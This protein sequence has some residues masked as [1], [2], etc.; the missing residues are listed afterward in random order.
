MQEFFIKNKVFII[1]V[2]ATLAVFIGGIYLSSRGSSESTTKVSMDIL[3]PA[4]AQKISTPSATITL[5][6]FGDYECPACAT[7]N[8]FVKKLLVDEVDKVNF[9]F[10]DYPLPQHKNAN[11]SS[12]AA[13]AAALQGKFW[14]MHDKLFETQNDWAQVSDPKSIFIGYAKELGLNEVQFEKDLS[15]D[16][17]KKIVEQGTT[18][19]SLVKLD[20]TPTFYLNGVKMTL[21]ATYE[22]FR[23]LI[24]SAK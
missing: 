20:S 14:Q 18:D 9:V 1:G 6:E 21:P 10:R 5:V 23:N 12:Y 4:S 7:Y 2:L 24:I 16:S 17:I 22:E 15:L 11:I 3:A 19:G 8:V 13:E